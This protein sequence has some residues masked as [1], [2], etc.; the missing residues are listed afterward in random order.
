M[1]AAEASVLRPL[2][3]LT[4]GCA[5]AAAMALASPAAPPAAAWSLMSLGVATVVLALARH[6]RTPLLW[7]LAGLALGGARGLDA[8]AD[9]LVLAGW[10]G[11]REE[12]VAL[13]VEVRVRE[14]WSPARWGRRSRVE[15]LEASRGEHPVR[16]PAVVSLE[17][18]GDPSAALPAPGTVVGTLAELRGDPRRPALVAASPRLLRVLAPPSG[19]HAVR[20]RLAGAVLSA[21]GTDVDRI[22]AAELAG[23]LALGRR[24]LLPVERREAWRRSGL[25]HLLAVSGLHVGVVAAA[26]WMVLVL[27]GARPVTARLVLL[28]AVPGYALLAGAAPS[29]MRAALMVCVWLVA[30]LLGRSPVP[31]AAVLA[32]VAGMLL[33]SPSLIH[34]V[35]F[36]LTVLVTAAL[37]RWVPE[38][39]ERLPGPPKVAAA[40]AVPVVA[41]VAAGPLIAVHFR[42]VLPGAALVNLAAAP[43]L[44]PALL[45]AAGSVIAAPV[46]PGLARPCLDLLAAIVA[47]IHWIGGAA[48][49]ASWTAPSAAPVLVAVGAVLAVAALLPGRAGRAGAAAWIALVA[50]VGLWSAIRPSRLA[51]V[52]LLPVSDGTAVVVSGSG[53]AVLVDG[54]RFSEEA[55]RLLADGA[56]PAV[57]CVVAS[58]TDEDHIGGLG[59]VIRGRGPRRLVTPAWAMSDPDLVPLLRELRR[60]GGSVV[61]VASGSVVAGSGWR[62]E[63]LWP[64][65]AAPA[66]SRNERSLVARVR[67]A[68]GTVLVT[69]DIGSATERTIASRRDL[70][71]D[72]LVA[73]H[74]GSRTS[75]SPQLLAAAAPT[76]VLVPAG[77]HNP[78]HH[79][80]PDVIARLDRMGLEW[81]L[82]EED[83]AVGAGP[84]SEG[85]RPQR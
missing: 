74:H 82:P 7:L 49:A 43:L 53:A 78:H 59:Q 76:V 57:E 72:V 17:V 33:T 11:D 24:D 66:G 9:Q 62:L 77:I 36:Q 54:G 85:W 51:P 52:A 30:R 48:R 13:R 34:D 20:E 55:V 61:P 6:P 4:G 45:A 23:A 19:L 15:V 75:S 35:G 10:L 25:A 64:P 28:A 70:R 38:L 63:V 39:A 46:L 60:R 31:M 37:V 32:A 44:A 58:H 26:L 29:A 50:A 56:A 22:R 14:A 69:S 42:T 2:W 68:E 16:L 84:T 71:C 47:L 80:H 41:Q 83:L 27:A 1:S 3:L 18:R 73:P 65:A 79:P 12:T 67:V 21:A 8:R 5:A 81:L 40:V